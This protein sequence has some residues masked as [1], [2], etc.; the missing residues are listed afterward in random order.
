MADKPFDPRFP[1]VQPLSD[2]DPWSQPQTLLRGRHAPY[3]G[4]GSLSP[5]VNGGLVANTAS[6]AI[7]GEVTWIAAAHQYATSINVTLPVGLA[8]VK[9]LD[10]PVSYR[11]MLAFRN[12]NPVANL[13]VQFGSNASLLSVF[14]VV[15]NA[16]FLFDS[17]VPQ[18]DIYVMSD[19]AGSQF[20]M[21]YST[22]NLPE[23]PVW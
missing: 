6:S 21:V 8:S 10:A 16:M 9:V 1:P 19:T 3:T 14:R 5:G 4:R 11:N 17:V 20:S 13:F 23:R 7:G 12:P 15:P 22:V 2:L 18:D